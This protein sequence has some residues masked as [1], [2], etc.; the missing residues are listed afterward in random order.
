M[1]RGREEGPN[2]AAANLCVGYGTFTNAQELSDDEPAGEA[3]R[4][5]QL[6]GTHTMRFGARRPA[7]AEPLPDLG[8]RSR[9]SH[10]AG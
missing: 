5:W 8:N 6:G 9:G 3:E 10:W 1:G 7:A 2:R 4:T